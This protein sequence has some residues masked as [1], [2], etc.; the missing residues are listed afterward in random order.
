MKFYNT[1][2]HFQ[3]NV[4]KYFIATIDKN[5]PYIHIQFEVPTH[6]VCLILCLKCCNAAVINSKF[7]LNLSFKLLLYPLFICLYKKVAKRKHT[8]FQK[9]WRMKMTKNVTILSVY[10]LFFVFYKTCSILFLRVKE[11]H[12]RIK[13]FYLFNSHLLSNKISIRHMKDKFCFC[14][15]DPNCTYRLMG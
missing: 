13:K 9:I 2:P 4:T 6:L 3:W 14:W 5:L 8:P 1:N 15:S 12:F 11:I 10:T 7:N